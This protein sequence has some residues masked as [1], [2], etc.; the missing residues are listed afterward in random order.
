MIKLFRGR[1]GGEPANFVV[2]FKAKSMAT[3]RHRVGIV[4]PRD[5]VW[6]AL[7]TPQGLSGWWAS[8]ASI[9]PA[10]VHLAFTG[11]T[12]LTFS[13]LNQEN[14]SRLHLKNTV[15]PHPWGGSE[16]EFFLSAADAQ[17]FVTLLHHHPEASEED[18]QFFMTKWPIFLVSLKRFVETGIGNPFPNDIKI[19]ADL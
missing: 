11:L 8:S 19:Q 3:I 15:D 6:E 1:R 7:T 12:T 10:T 14:V 2:R 9:T 4:A 16:L 17:V 18:F 13:I 5:K